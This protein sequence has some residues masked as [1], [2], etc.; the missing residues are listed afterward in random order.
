LLLLLNDMAWITMVAPVGM[1]VAQNLL[2]GLAVYLDTG[3]Q[4][5][6]KPVFPRWV[7]HFAV[8]TGVAMA[9][10]AAAAVFHSGPLAWD[11]AISFWLRIGAF[12]LFIAV[13][14]FVLRSTLHRQA[15]EEGVACGE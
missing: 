10:A 15:V 6:P 4:G 14:F 13:M 12:V 9:P 1:L 3:R 7:G 5:S 2:L 11:G 8:V